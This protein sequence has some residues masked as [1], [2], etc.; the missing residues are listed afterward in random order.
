MSG[1]EEF[2]DL[3]KTGYSS[4]EPVK[5][6]DEFFHSVYICG[7]SRENESGVTEQPDKL[8]VRGVEYNLD[9]VFMII[10]NVKKVL[11]KNEQ[12]QGRDKTTCF[13]YK[14]GNGP[15]NGTSG[16]PCGSNSSERAA[17]TFCGPCKEQIIVSG[18]LCDANGRPKTTS[19]G[20][21]QFGFI[22][23]KGLKYSNVGNYLNDLSKLD[24]DPIFEP[25]TLESKKF[26]KAV[27]NNKRFVTKI[28]QTTADSNRGG[29]FNVYGLEKTIELPKENVKKILE[30]SK[31]TMEEFNDKFNWGKRMQNNVTT[32][33]GNTPPAEENKFEFAG[34][35]ENTK[36]D[37]QPEQVEEVKPDESVSFDDLN[38]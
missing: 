4:R 22:R 24:L 8:Q 3:E 26:E 35:G 14:E 10:T 11:A 23:G 20:K 18:I 32:G 17:S 30:I 25:V 15:W 9:E 38:F 28:T 1:F 6:E 19:E 33:Y 5:P 27:V 2:A 12:V 31:K 16:N 7:K 29:T 34:E 36:T 13:S 37:S 21:P